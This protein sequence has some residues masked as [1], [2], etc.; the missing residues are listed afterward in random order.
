MNR[1]GRIDPRSGRYLVGR[2]T[3][4]SKGVRQEGYG[5]NVDLRTG[6]PRLGYGTHLRLG[7]DGY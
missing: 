7:V 6:A 1:K 2:G 5:L 3:G 4:A